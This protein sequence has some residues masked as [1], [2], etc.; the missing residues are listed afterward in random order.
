MH[1]QHTPGE[2]GKTAYDCVTDLVLEQSHVIASVEIL[3]IDAMPLRTPTAERIHKQ[4]QDARDGP[5]LLIRAQLLLVPSTSTANLPA[6]LL[7]LDSAPQADVLVPDELPKHV[8]P[9]LV[10]G[11]ILVE[12]VRDPVES[13]QARPRDGWKVMMFVVKTNVV[14]QHVERP[15]VRVRFRQWDLV[16]RVRSVLVRLLKNVVL[17][18]EMACAGMQRSSQEA[19]HDKV[20]QRSSTCVLYQG[21]V[22]CQLDGNVQEVNLGH[23]QTVYEHGSQGVEKDLESREKG[24]TSDGVEEEGLESGWQIGIKAID[25]QGLVMGEVVGPE[26]GAIWDANWQVCKDGKEAVCRW[27]SEGQVM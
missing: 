4:L 12:V 16:R 14:R 10:L 6:S 23:R 9:A 20:S 18:D 13:G 2:F 3:C 21:V 8:Y 1:R 7:P 11:E 5:L 25:A 24:F 27:R 19:A 22:K 17:G 26:R 15:I